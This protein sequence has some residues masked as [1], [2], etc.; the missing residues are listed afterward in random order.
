MEEIQGE[1]I[2]KFYLAN[3]CISPFIMVGVIINFSI[4]FIK[5]RSQISFHLHLILFA[6]SFLLKQQMY[7]FEIYL[8]SFIFWFSQSLFYAG[9]CVVLYTL[10]YI[11]YSHDK[12]LNFIDTI[13]IGTPVVHFTLVL[14]FHS[15]I[16]EYATIGMLS[17]TIYLCFVYF[18]ITM[19]MIR[20]IREKEIG[21][22]KIYFIL[23]LTFL[24]VMFFINTVFSIMTII[25]RY[26]FC[27]IHP[28]YDILNSI[29]LV[30]L[31]LM[32][33]NGLIL[34]DIFTKYKEMVGDE[35]D[36]I[37]I[38]PTIDIGF[39]MHKKSVIETQHSSIGRAVFLGRN[40]CYKQI[41]L[42]ELF[43]PQTLRDDLMKL[44]SLKYMNVQKTE[45]MAVTN[46]NVYVVYHHHFSHSMKEILET[47]FSF[48]E[49]SILKIV[50]G[51]ISG[52]LRLE[53]EGIIHYHLTLNNIL[54]NETKNRVTIVDFLP[55]MKWWFDDCEEYPLFFE[56]SEQQFIQKIHQRNIRL[57]KWLLYRLV[58]GNRIGNE[59]SENIEIEKLHE[60]GLFY[61]LLVLWS[62]SNTN[63]YSELLE[64]IEMVKYPFTTDD[65]YKSYQYYSTVSFNNSVLE[66]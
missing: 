47:N 4:I 11:Y 62:Q 43:S 2:D 44:K 22:D 49:Y 18:C 35:E 33:S 9:I 16:Y 29:I 39:L 7:H 37:V 10:F 15:I 64:Q 36:D 20:I 59:I 53:S 61:N 27:F 5:K 57:I 34:L 21:Y 1:L 66:I 28:L 63:S 56:I 55:L 52:L 42:D 8:Q 50:K 45:G 30:I 23:S 6:L 19:S 24:G 46:L 26:P 41:N 13:I 40:V 32:I 54:L 51:L 25:E 58:C 48:P 12:C 38:K 3:A 60:D 14:I 17:F 65:T 31:S